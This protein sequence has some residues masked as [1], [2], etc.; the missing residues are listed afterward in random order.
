MDAP[1]WWGNVSLCISNL[2]RLQQIYCTIYPT[3]QSSTYTLLPIPF[4]SYSTHS[5][6]Q[7]IKK[8]FQPFLQDATFP[9]GL[10]TDLLSRFSSKEGYEL[11]PDVLPFFEKLRM[12][13]RDEDHDRDAW[14][15]QRTTVG[16]VT[17]SD[18]RVPFILRSFG[19]RVGPRFH[20][21]SGSWQTKLEDEND[22]DFVV[23]SYD[24]G[25]EKPHPSIFH[26][27]C[28]AARGLKGE[29]DLA[30]LY[31]G[32]EVNKDVVGALDAGWEAVL[33]DRDQVYKGSEGEILA[34]VHR[35]AGESLYERYVSVVRD[36]D[37]I[38]PR[39]EA[40]RQE[41][42]ESSQLEIYTA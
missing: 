35:N 7:I 33:V 3:L 28:T 13:K 21:N 37:I 9:S 38:G 36:L 31:V 16:I 41:S 34:H 30:M 4:F 14:P 40:V 15:W 24:I 2:N 18:D 29:E 25:E 26:A 22:I 17:N 23:L 19:L 6:D 5:A 8:T 42:K 1:E 32:D 39:L 10:I 20:P 11:Y 27:A 12:I